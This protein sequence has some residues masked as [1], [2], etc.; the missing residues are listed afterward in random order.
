MFDTHSLFGYST[1]QSGSGVIGSDTGTDI[2][3]DTGDGSNFSTGQNI[4]VWPAGT[5]P[6]MANAEIMRI[7]GI[8]TD[9]L[10][11]TRAQEGTT[12]LTGITAGY[13]FANTITPKVF[14]D[15]ETS[16]SDNAT[17]LTGKQDVLSEGAFVDGDKTK[18]DGI[19]AGAEVNPTS[20]DE[21]GP[22]QTG[23]AGK[24]LTT[25]GTNASWGT[26]GG[27]G[28]ML[29]AT[30]DPNTVAGDA[31]DQDNMVSGTTNKN[32]TATEQTKLAG[33]EANADVTDTANVTAAGAL[34]DSE[35]TNL[36][37][38]KAFD[39]ADYATAAQGTTADSAV[40]PGD[41]ISTLTNDSGFT[42]NTG[43]VTSVGA[44]VPTGMTVSGSPVTGSGTLALGYDTGY[45]G[46]TSTEATKL[47][48]IESGA[49]VNNISD[50]NATDLTDAGDSTLHYHATDRSRANHTG[51]QTAST[52]SDFSTAA[53]ARIAAATATGTGSLVR[54]TSPT[55]A[56]TPLA[57]TASAG[58][59]TTQIATTAHVY[60]ERSNTATLS[61]KRVTKRSTSATSASS[62]TP[63]ISTTD[64]YEYTALAAN[65]TINA[66]TGTP[67]NGD[68]LM[69]IIKDNGTSRT[70]TWNATYVAVGVTLP[71]ATTTSK[72]HVVG[73]RYSSSRTRWEV[74]AVTE[75]A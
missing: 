44:T 11:V 20:V 19:E 3:A 15:I 29:A 34:M 42:T 57:P 28:D 2:V 30:Y 38:V 33:I 21:L 39:P 67:A 75:E 24:F 74:I 10:T 62:L 66:P 45:Q 72:V 59:N 23:N 60:A 4:T 31:F 64:E 73:A 50:V 18:L 25:N 36:A 5:Q 49:E 7:T 35:V 68:K 14:T 46:Y 9:T 37:D 58:T 69:F 32:Y 47:A 27:S 71:T 17:A 51:T 26:P 63:D 65:L 6:T 70:L 56:G 54:A 12:A 22:S 16:T 1:V 40:Q 52:I 55:L 43:T 8:S 13:Q 41:N 61:N 53:D 48:G